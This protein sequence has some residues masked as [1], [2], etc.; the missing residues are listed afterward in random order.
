ML[1][2]ARGLPLDEMIV[3]MQIALSIMIWF[4]GAIITLVLYLACLFFTIIFYLFDKQ[5][6][7]VHAQ[8]F[9]WS[10]AVIALNPYWDVQITGL[11]NINKSRTY[12][13]VAN[14]QSLADIV[15]LYKIHAQFKW[16]SKESVF[17]VPLIGWCLSLGRHIKLTRGKFDS[18][19]KVYRQ[20]AIWLKEDMS[21]LFFPEGTRSNTGT[22]NKFQN[23][24]FKLAIKENIPILPICLQGT[25]NAI[26]KG[27][28]IFKTKA[29]VKVSVLPAIETKDL[30]PRDFAH[31]NET[32]YNQIKGIF[33]GNC[34][35]NTTRL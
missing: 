34:Y 23:G 33:T 21:V 7:I 17:R 24:A 6:R 18:I 31:L 35:P 8:C 30:L 1:P 14:H 29:T 2:K 10:N 26:P 16:V 25:R 3:L 20:A 12:V 5:R 28:W 15:V 27:G 13:I 4:F 11:E 32:T 9:W 19:K 22:M